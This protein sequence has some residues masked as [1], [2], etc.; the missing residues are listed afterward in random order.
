MHHKNNDF[1]IILKKN[2][3][4]MIDEGLKLRVERRVI[5]VEGLKMRD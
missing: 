5:K 2:S 4:Q 1:L 3:W